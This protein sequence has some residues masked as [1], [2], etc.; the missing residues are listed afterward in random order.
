MGRSLNIFEK[1]SLKL[2]LGCFYFSANF[3]LTVLIKLFLH[4]KVYKTSAVKGLI[5]I[6]IFLLSIRTAN[7]S[8]KFISVV[9]I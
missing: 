1:F 8:I 7:Q 4:K 2:L 6:R 9:L 3:S 5:F